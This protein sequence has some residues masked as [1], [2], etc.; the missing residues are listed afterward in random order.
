MLSAKAIVSGAEVRCGIIGLAVMVLS[1]LA[2]PAA[3]LDGV[4]AK[5]GRVAGAAPGKIRDNLLLLEE[6]YNQEP[7]VIQHIQFLKFTPAS[8]AWDFN[9]TEEWPVPTDRH[10]LSI[11]VPVSGGGSSSGGI[12][13]LVVSYRLQVLG[14][15]G[16]GWLALAPRLSA[17]IP[18]GD[19]ET[20]HGRGAAGAQFNLPM[21]MDLGRYLTA[22]V[23]TGL[24]FTPDARSPAGGKAD[25][26][27][28]NLGLALVWLP[29]GW[30]NALV[31]VAHL[32]T[33]EPADGSGTV[34]SASFIVN[35]GVRFAVDFDWGLQIVPAL[36]APVEWTSGEIV[37]SGLVYL[38]FEHP[39][40]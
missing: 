38:S 9:F 2:P 21:S 19:W 12:S 8:G 37:Y 17:V 1:A 7:G 27:D 23:N 29:T 18:T 25:A 34:R 10:Q 20:G 5:I 35:P 13:D 40:W 28:T 3:A 6:A 22:H 14:A 30:A 15:G 39:L 33:E 32:T 11:T 16:K 24:S 26:L 4:P 31:E 36:S